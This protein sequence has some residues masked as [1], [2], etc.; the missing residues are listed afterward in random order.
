MP[1][2]VCVSFLHTAGTSALLQGDSP[3]VPNNDFSTYSADRHER[4]FEPGKMYMLQAYYGWPSAFFL[5]Q[6]KLVVVGHTTEYYWDL[7]QRTTGVGYESLSIEEPTPFIVVGVGGTAD[8][9]RSAILGHRPTNYITGLIGEHLCFI[10][11]ADIG[12]HMEL[13]PPE[14]MEDQK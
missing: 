14:E 6:K 5:A 1:Y 4:V 11:K 2:D 7:V 8:G 3:I 13:P 9:S 10:C 12:L